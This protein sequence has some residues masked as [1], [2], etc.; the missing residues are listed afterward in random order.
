MRI[1]VRSLSNTAGIMTVSV[2]SV[3][4]GNK[5]GIMMTILH[6][7]SLSYFQFLCPLIEGEL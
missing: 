6:S 4:L 3:S 7:L 1:S 5:E 2:L